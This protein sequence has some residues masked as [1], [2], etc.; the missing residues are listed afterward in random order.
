MIEYTQ[1]VSIVIWMSGIRTL[2]RGVLSCMPCGARKTAV[3][4]ADKSFSG[5][6]YFNCSSARGGDW[7]P[8][9]CSLT[10][11]PYQPLTVDKCGVFFWKSIAHSD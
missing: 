2:L 7:L 11:A 9:H 5:V 10:C 6:V 1:L 8:T 4:P 3:L